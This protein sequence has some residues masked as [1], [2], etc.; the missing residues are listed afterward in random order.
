[1]GSDP[2]HLSKEEAQDISSSLH[3]VSTK[4]GDLNAEHIKHGFINKKT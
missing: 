4:Y 3:K 1:M 2:K